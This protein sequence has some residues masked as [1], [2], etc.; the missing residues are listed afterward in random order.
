MWWDIWYKIFDGSPWENHN[1]DENDLEL[2]IRHIDDNIEEY[3]PAVL[4]VVNS[5]RSKAMALLLDRWWYY[6]SDWIVVDRTDEKPNRRYY[7]DPKYSFRWKEN[8]ALHIP[9]LEIWTIRKRKPEEHVLYDVRIVHKW[10]EKEVTLSHKEYN[11]LKKFVAALWNTIKIINKDRYTLKDLLAS[12]GP[13][14]IWNQDGTNLYGIPVVLPKAHNNATQEDWN[15]EKVLDQEGNE[16]P[17]FVRRFW[18]VVK[19]PAWVARQKEL[20]RV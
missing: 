20:R 5:E 7:D 16:I 19:N 2:G 12:I 6:N 13:W 8:I 11:L 10:N 4:A 18:K 9:G 15:D 1:V 3:D 14:I 17:E